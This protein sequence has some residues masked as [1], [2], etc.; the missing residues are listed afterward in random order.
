MIQIMAQQ[1][2]LLQNRAPTYTNIAI[3]CKS[4]LMIAEVNVILEDMYRIMRLICCKEL[5]HFLFEYFK[6]N[7]KLL[8]LLSRIAESGYFLI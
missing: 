3:V 7:S 4:I 5:A 1:N 8:S 2:L 6:L